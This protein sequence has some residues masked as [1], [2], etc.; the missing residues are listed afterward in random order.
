MPWRNRPMPLGAA[1]PPRA[2]GGPPGALRA[3]TGVLAH[4]K[5]ALQAL[6]V[7]PLRLEPRPVGPHPL[8]AVVAA[9]LLQASLAELLGERG[10]VGEGRRLEE[11]PRPPPRVGVLPG[12]RPDGAAPAD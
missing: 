8:L 9:Q 12:Q 2:G 6:Q 3:A 10:V 5:A 7:L 4:G 11:G 1:P